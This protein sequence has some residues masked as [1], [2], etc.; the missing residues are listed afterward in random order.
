LGGLSIAYAVA[1][2][3]TTGLV[4]VWGEWYSPS[5]EYRMQTEAFFEGRLSISTDVRDVRTDTAW[6]RQGVHQVWG[7]G[8]PAWRAPFE[9]LA[10]I[11]G[12][13][14]FPDRLAFGAFMVLTVF[15]ALRVWSDAV[16]R[17]HPFSNE[18]ARNWRLLFAICAGFT[19]PFFSPSFFTL[20][21]SRGAVYEEAVAYGY[22]F[23]TLQLTLLISFARK[24]SVRSLMVLCTLAGIG[25]FV[26]PTLVFYGA[27]TVLLAFCLWVFACQQNAGA[28]NYS[29]I[30]YPVMAGSVLFGVGGGFLWLTNLLRFGSGFEFGHQLNVQHIYGSMYAT[31]F[32]HPFSEV[33]IL[34]AF[35]EL[36]GSL[37][38]PKDL[39]G[40]AW[41]ADQI[42]AGQSPA[43]RWRNFYFDTFNPCYVVVVFIGWTAALVHFKSI[44]PGDRSNGIKSNTTLNLGSRQRPDGCLLSHILLSKRY[45]VLLGGW[46][47]VSSVCLAA[48]YLYVPV[49][50]SR[51]IVD[52]APALNAGISAAW[53][54]ATERCIGNRIRLAPICLLVAWIGIEI[55][56]SQTVYGAPVSLDRTKLEHQIFGDALETENIAT[57]D[58]D[59]TEQSLYST[60]RVNP[61]DCGG[62]DPES[63]VLSPI[64][65][66]FV[67]NP[68]YI[69]LELAEKSGAR[70]LA[71]P[72]DIRVK[73]GLEYLER[74]FIKAS[75]D[76]YL[77]RFH[78]P[79]NN[80]WKHGIQTVFIATV[81]KH[82]LSEI[83][84]PW[85]LKSVRWTTDDS[86]IGD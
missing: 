24:P 44:L 26:R 77:I 12:L 67:E 28:R 25:G 85:I 84:T 72:Q 66:L 78:G 59:V 51:Y 9:A 81:P 64:V 58:V 2:L 60:M 65:I 57:G 10:R 62:W 11:I 4:P 5:I 40:T 86:G 16:L 45:I 70:V 35:M 32:D 76:G 36:F 71:R 34:D 50:S 20:L 39:N 22:L 82:S 68:D 54:L 18:S 56:S 42:F 47:L 38:S 29:R 3:W 15:F 41:Y 83:K 6:A 69:E 75:D 31:R 79:K 37:F 8:I 30:L 74:D 80:I 53:I 61:F 17:A 23:S 33:T 73:V 63:G 19:I 1:V 52:F 46:S 48:F 21:R 7:L 49:I 13:S 27:T 14:S 55:L 43:V